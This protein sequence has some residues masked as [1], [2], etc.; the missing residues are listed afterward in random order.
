MSWHGGAIRACL[1]LLFLGSRDT[2][3]A[4]LLRYPMHPYCPK[5]LVV[6]YLCLVHKKVV[7][8]ALPVPTTAAVVTT[9]LFCFY[10][11]SGCCCHSQCCCGTRKTGAVLNS[12][13]FNGHIHL[14][15][16]DTCAFLF[17]TFNSL[18]TACSCRY[19]YPTTTTIRKSWT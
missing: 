6:L 13:L 14:S 12:W 11:C 18:S 10:N 19:R 3:Y 8:T 9:S 17:Y 1:G 7:T 4:K 16:A 15:L 5:V 2:V